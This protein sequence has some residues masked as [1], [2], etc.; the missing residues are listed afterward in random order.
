MKKKLL[1]ILLLS[2]FSMMSFAMNR[3]IQNMEEHVKKERGGRGAPYEYVLRLD[4]CN[5]RDQDMP[6]VVSFLQSHQDIHDLN[7][8]NNLLT[9]KSVQILLDSSVALSQLNISSNDL[10]EKG[11]LLLSQFEAE[12]ISW[13][14]TSLRVSNN[15][16]TDKGA[17]ALAKNTTFISMDLE[18]NHIGNAGIIA[19]ANNTAIEYLH[20]GYNEVTD[21]GAIELARLTRLLRTGI[22]RTLDVS[23]NRIGKAGK[24]ELIALKENRLVGNLIL[25]GNIE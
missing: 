24:Q 22:I 10:G 18:K 4:S 14:I 21:E 7:V 15:N 25:V 9:H 13:Y 16:L 19:L 23:Y 11:A 8:S 20:L 1:M 3:C 12:P 2:I 5:L 6:D 17:E